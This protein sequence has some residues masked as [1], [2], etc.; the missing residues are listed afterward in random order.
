MERIIKLLVGAVL[1]IASVL[2][3]NFITAYAQEIYTIVDDTQTDATQQNYFTYSTAKDTSGLKGW[4]SDKKNSIQD[5]KHADAAKTQHW[6]WNSNNTEA[7]KHTYSF[8]FEGTGVILYGV[9]NDVSNTFQLDEEAPQKTAISGSANTITPLYTK[10]NLPMGKHTVKV[11]LPN[12][13]SH[14]GLQVS[15]A[16]VFK[17]ASTEDT[18]EKT[19]IPFTKMDGT[20]NRFTYSS[21]GWSSFGS[22]TEHVWSDNPADKNTWY[23]VTFTGS[24]IDIYAGKNRPMGKVKYTVDGVDYGTYSLY[25]NGNINSTLIKTIDGLT[26]GKHILRAEATGEKEANA[27]GTGIDCA[28]VVVY[29]APYTVSDFSLKETNATLTEGATFQIQAIPVPDYAIL[30]DLTYISDNP[31]IASVD[32]NGLVSANG[33]G[34]TTIRVKA[35]NTTVSKTA[36]IT[37]QESSKQIKGSIVDTNT[38]YTQDTYNTLKGMGTMSKTVSAWVNDKAISELALISIDSKLKNVAIEAS[39]FK[40]GQNTIAKS[41]ITTTFIRS[42]KAY[43]GAYLGYGSTT[44]PVPAPTKTNRSESNDILYQNTPIEIPYNAVQPV[45]IEMNVPKGTAPGTYTG[46]IRVSADEIS[47]P[48]TFTY[49]LDVQ[50]AQLPDASEFEKNFD[51]ELWQYPYSSAEYYNVTPFS[52]K[53]LAILKPIMEKYKS[54]GGHAITTSIIEDAWGGQTYSKHAIHYPSMVKWVKHEDGSFSYDYTDFDKWVQFNK[55]LG[56][57]DKIVIYSIAPWN[58]AFTYWE[59][60]TLKK[61]PYTVGSKRYTDVWTAF[62]QN[63]VQHLDAKGWF[64]DS[65]IGIDERGFSKAAFDVVDSVKNKDGKSLKTAGAMDGF[66]DKHDLAMR[67]TDLNVGDTAAAAHSDAF[68]QLLK[69]R[70]AKGDR[71]TLYSCTEHKPGNFSLSAPSESYWSI[72]NAAKAGTAGFLRWAYDAWVEDPL[73]DATHNAF[74]P[75]DAFLIYPDKKDAENPQVHS[76]VRLE[77]MAE[78]VR[79]VNKIAKMVKEIPSL[80]TDV[81]ALYAKVTMRATTSRSY[82]NT[83][84][85]KQ[86]ATEMD[87]F[88]AGLYELT[89]KYISIKT[90]GTTEV[91]SVSIH[92]GNSLSIPEGT[93]EQ[94]H[95]TVL[96]STLIDGTVSWSTSNK[97][98]VD[99]T[100]DGLI[101]ANT[102]GTATISAAANANSSKTASIQITVTNTQI[103]KQAEV[104]YYNFDDGN[105][106]QV[107]DAWGDANGTGSQVSSIDGI[108]GKALDLTTAQSKVTIANPVNVGTTW[109][110]SM[111]VYQKNSVKARASLL[112]NGV[113]DPNSVSIDAANGPHNSA[114]PTNIGVHV[115]NGSNGVL[116]IS[117]AMPSGKWTNLAVTNSKTTGLSFYIDGNPIGSPNPWT[118]THDMLLPNNI[119][120]GLGFIGKLDEIKIYNKVLNADE[121]RNAMAVKGLNIATKSIEMEIGK[122]ANIETNLMSDASDKTITY[123]SMDPTIASVNAFGVVSGKSFGDT[124]ITVKGGGYEDKVFV[125]ITKELEIQYTIPQYNLPDKNITTFARSATQYY[126]QPDMVLLDDNKTMIGVYPEGHGVGNVLMKRSEDAGKTWQ[127]VTNTPSSWK[128]SQETPTLYK[129]DFKDG[130]QK[131]IMITG[132][133]A[134]WGDYSTGWQTSVSSDG[135][136]TWSEYK[137]YHE[138]YATTVAMASLIR[139]K[140]KDGNDIDKWMGVFH[141]GGNFVNYKTYLTFDKD[142]NEQWSEPQPYLSE[143]RNIES[144]YQI[145][146]VGMFR[147]PDGKRI[148]ALARSQSHQN[149]STMFYSDDEGQTW[150]KPRDLPG[151]LQGER[152]KIAYDP[153]SGRLLITFREITLDYNKNGKI[154]PNDWMAGDWVAWVGTYDDLLR[155]KE[156]QYRIRLKEDFTNNAKGGDCGY[157]GVTVQPDGT[158]TLISYGHFDKEVAEANHTGNARND[159]AYIVQA[160][161]KLSEMDTLAGIIRCH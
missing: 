95:A 57:G 96:P 24:K 86:L 30:K 126:G 112:W 158:F 80:Q 42:T 41:N 121:V 38:Q 161:F 85:R 142:G 2:P 106:K 156:G 131:L 92:E 137:R 153:I 40:N 129:L 148:M 63:L 78:G 53:H 143:W 144:K 64:N 81:K 159:P 82:L 120:G 83:S 13:G 69:D 66:V 15:Y 74:E 22:S 65:Y 118:K 132:C 152:H 5:N 141:N 116:S 62:L 51:I 26:E 160:Q 90:Q 84:Q 31:N 136:K 123:E 36:D 130:S 87:A 16:K 93:T 134:V 149:K 8:T 150:S 145:C 1:A 133:P 49:T 117:N 34:K 138:G 155:G 19:T 76:S 10:K 113:S 128:T 105:V 43:N 7:S 114:S 29:H 60:G 58:N 151:A 146:E 27:T 23:E 102:A 98:I 107:K 115:K 18:L 71:T 33:V 28:N 139:L 73:Q 12:D 127:S 50:D 52:Q 56:I 135:G 157:A 125:R 122:Q 54:I 88:K 154:E 99:V 48:L 61:E 110:V 45:W 108:S 17:E 37:V 35:S 4:A 11:T 6:V 68:A 25:N 109:S 9:K 89:E 67:V 47:E 104:A 44:R 103:D 32:T 97:A 20:S 21:T 124:W 39:D 14:S 46:T 140:D 101:R 94:L 111:W 75:G 3:T 100:K 70:S 119:I 77:K 79:D 91:S 55:D 147:S 59:N 72:V